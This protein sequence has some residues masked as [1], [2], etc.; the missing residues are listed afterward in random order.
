VDALNACITPD[1]FDAI[2]H[3]SSIKGAVSC[4]INSIITT[5]SDAPPFS[6]YTQI[7]TA[8]TASSTPAV[9][10][11]TMHWPNGQAFT[12]YNSSS[13]TAGISG[14]INNFPTIGG[15][16]LRQLEVIFLWCLFALYV[17]TLPYRFI[18]T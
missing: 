12:V 13:T 9:V 17:V 6:W 2:F 4:S 5:F 8:V 7:R 18:K 14:R 1:L 3:P 11:L 10:D 15:K 16:T